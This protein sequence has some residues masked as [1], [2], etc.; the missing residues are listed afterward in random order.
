MSIEDPAVRVKLGT[1]LARPGVTIKA[2]QAACERVKETDAP[3]F[4]V[5]GRRLYGADD[6][7]F[8][9]RWAAGGD[10]QMAECAGSG[11]GGVQ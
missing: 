3:D 9:C 8:Q 5:G 2:I 7:A 4:I 10:R 1:V 6:C 11:S